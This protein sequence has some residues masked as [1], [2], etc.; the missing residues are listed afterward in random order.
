LALQSITVTGLREVLNFKKIVS[1]TSRIFQNSTISFPHGRKHDAS[2]LD[3]SGLLVC[4]VSLT[5]NLRKELYIKEI[6]QET[7]G[8]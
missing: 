8:S 1:S 4:R 7:K 6:L 3:E 5:E 2:M